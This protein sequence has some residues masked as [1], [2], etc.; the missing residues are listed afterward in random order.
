MPL[1][2]YAVYGHINY[3]ESAIEQIRVDLD[4]LQNDFLEVTA[5]P[6]SSQPVYDQMKQDIARDFS[7][8][9]VALLDQKYGERIDEVFLSDLKRMFEF[10]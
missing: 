6:T 4:R 5:A 8:K 3:T 1:N 2:E 10:E 9:L 7:E